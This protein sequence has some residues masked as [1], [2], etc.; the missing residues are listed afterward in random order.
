MTFGCHS[1]NTKCL[2]RK[3]YQGKS[4]PITP[5]PI[6]TVNGNHPWFS[7]ASSPFIVYA[8][9]YMGSFLI[10]TYLVTFPGI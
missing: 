4:L 3:R 7:I 1:L 8:S 9:L 2:L 10:L 6:Y 5:N